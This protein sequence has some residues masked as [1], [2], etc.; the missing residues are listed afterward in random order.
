MDLTEL[1]LEMDKT[2]EELLALFA[3]RMA[4]SGE[5]ARWKMERNRPI[6]D[7]TREEE[8]LRRAALSVPEELRPNARELMQLLMAQSRRLQEKILQSEAT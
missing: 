6:F 4:L 1:R 8:K 2:D 3:R 5:I 7:P